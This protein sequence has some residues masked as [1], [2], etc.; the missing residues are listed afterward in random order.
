MVKRSTVWRIIFSNASIETAN[1]HRFLAS[2]N[3]RAT[4]QLPNALFHL[5]CD[6]SHR[7]GATLR[8]ARAF[9]SIGSPKI[10]FAARLPRGRKGAR[11]YL[12][13]VDEAFR[14]SAPT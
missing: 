4:H 10:T 14:Q 5:V 13:P 11:K 7:P 8:D 3:R 2:S 12:R 9:K 1:P 6:I